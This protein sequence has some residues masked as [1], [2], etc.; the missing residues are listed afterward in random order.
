MNGSE[1]DDTFYAQDDEADATISG[2]SGLG[3]G[4]HRHRSRSDADHRRARVRRR[5]ATATTGH[6]LHL[7]RRHEGGQGDARSRR[8]RDA[9]VVR[10]TDPVRHDA[11]GVRCGDDGQH[12]LDP[13][14]R[15]GRLG[16]EHHDRPVRRAVRP[17][18]DSS[19]REHPRSRSRSCSAT[20]PTG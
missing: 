2:G 14:H 16:R 20:R 12:R 3:H 5:R 1:G 9:R 7:R 19:S 4:V 8:R 11:G 10:R 13:R 18:R 6:R 17:G 15:R